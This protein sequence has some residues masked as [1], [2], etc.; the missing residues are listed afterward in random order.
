MKSPRTMRVSVILLSVLIVGWV[1]PTQAQ[2]ER[3]TGPIVSESVR[4]STSVPL[5]D[6]VREPRAPF[7][8]ESRDIN[9]LGRMPKVSRSGLSMGSERM[10]PPYPPDLAPAPLMSFNG[11][12]NTGWAPPDTVGDVGPNHY[13]QAVNTDYAVFN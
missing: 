6:M 12:G 7:E 3:S 5:R 8:G 4:H 11:I 13:V 9:P 2:T 10:P 1:L